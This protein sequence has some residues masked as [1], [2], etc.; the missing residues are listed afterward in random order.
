MNPVYACGHRADTMPPNHMR[1][2]R[3]L[4]LL[5]IVVPVAGCAEA[6]TPAP[7]PTAP[8]IASPDTTATSAT[9]KFVE[10]TDTAGL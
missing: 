7:R 8:S 10:I 3:L 5:L 1:Y 2:V 9:L 6:E 4:S